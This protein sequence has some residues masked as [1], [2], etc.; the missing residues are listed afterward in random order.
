MGLVPSGL[1]ILAVWAIYSAFGP[2]LQYG[3]GDGSPRMSWTTNTFDHGTGRLTET[4]FDRE[5]FPKADYELF[6]SYNNAGALTKL[7]ATH[8]QSGAAA[9]TQCFSMDHLQRLTKAWTPS[10]GDCTKA[11]SASTL[12]GPSP[13]FRE[14]TFDKA[15][16][17]KS[18]IVRSTAGDTTSTWAYPAV[19]QPKPHQATSVTVA[20]PG[21]APVVSPVEYDAAGNVT[22]RTVTAGAVTGA[23]AGARR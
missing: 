17:R 8:P 10:S 21:K 18:Q 15:S 1:W 5:T 9:D 4:R 3:T 7:R 14:W 16:N 12:G 11:A 19:G 20:A 2:L 13:Y 23:T 22:E 6:Y